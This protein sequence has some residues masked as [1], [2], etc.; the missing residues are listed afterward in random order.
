MCDVCNKAFTQSSHLK[1]HKLIHTGQKNHVCG[2]CKETFTEAGRLKQH[3]L[4]HSLH[5]CDVCNKT[6][7]EA[8]TLT[9]H[10]LVHATC[11]K[12]FRLR[13]EIHHFE[14]HK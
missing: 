7:T 9:Q 12:L 14:N 10:K 3:K 8:I 11:V 1:Q 6:F 2:V 13:T 5:V 4:I